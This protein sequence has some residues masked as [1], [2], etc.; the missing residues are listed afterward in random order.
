MDVTVLYFDGCPNWQVTLG[1]LEV[2]ATEI[3]DLH[4]STKLVDT[5][6][7]AESS[8]FMGS[9][10]VLINGIDAFAE[11]GAQVGLSCRVYHTPDGLAGSPTLNQL[12]DVLLQKGRAF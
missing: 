7:E 11:D 4:L 1:H 10:S 3:S 8:G 6:E 9:P 2:L 5:V 12:R